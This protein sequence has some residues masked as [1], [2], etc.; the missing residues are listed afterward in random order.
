MNNSLEAL[1]TAFESDDVISIQLK[2]VS[3]G[4]T[5]RL[6]AKGKAAE[7]IYAELKQIAEKESALVDLMKALFGD[8]M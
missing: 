3:K 7:E 2:I 5:G 8:P 4:S 6:R 1:F